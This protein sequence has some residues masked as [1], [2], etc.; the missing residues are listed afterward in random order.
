MRSLLKTDSVI[1]TSV[2]IDESSFDELGPEWDELLELSDQR[3][4]FLRFTWNRL[5]WRFL[6]PPDSELFIVACRDS[7]D[8]LV[9]LAPFYL[10]QRKTA[11]IPHVREL[12]FLGTGIYAQTSEYLDV[13]ARHG[14]ER[15][16]A[17]AT[18]ECLANDS[19]WDRLC[20]REI[21]ESSTMLSHLAR[22]L[23]EDAQ[24][25]PCN[26]SC[27]IDTTVGWESFK[28]GLSR[29]ARKNVLYGTRKL[30]SKHDCRLKRVGTLDE[31]DPAMDALIRL[32][33]AR[34][35]GKGEP[36]AFALINFEE[37]VREIARASLAEGSL[38]LLTLEID[39]AVAAARLGFQENHITH[40]FQ[41]GFDPAY[42]HE[43]V[44]SVMNGLT[45]KASFEDDYVHEYDFMGGSEAH[46]E[47]W[48]TSY[49]DSVSLTAIRPGTRS[50]AYRNL[51]LAK[52]M[53]K[54][55]VRATVPRSVRLAGHRLITQRHYK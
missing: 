16:V 51:E 27:Y 21:P 18:A 37:F 5:W 33:Q 29:S 46:K 54:S 39:G 35:Q 4:F 24:I 15:A 9:G 41:S 36:G 10:R 7:K 19:N 45:I 30:F 49:K 31:L 42:A 47:S 28:S 26:R 32:H 2:L 3:V 25:E 53:G 22:A 48:A 8:N 44:G 6:R 12:L 20:L 11:G 52:A 43:G 17:D 34:W 1:K 23:E 55:L 50:A 13:I 38:R 14:Y 40:A